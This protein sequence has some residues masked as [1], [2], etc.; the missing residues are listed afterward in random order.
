[1]KNDVEIVA[2]VLQG[3]TDVFESI[4]SRYKGCVYGLALTFLKDFDAA[5]DVAQEVF[6]RAF[7]NLDRLKDGDKLSAWLRSITA[8]TCKKWL[9]QRRDTLSITSQD[10]EGFVPP[11]LLPETPDRV[12]ERE[13]SRRIVLDGLSVLSENNRQALTLYYIDGLST[14]EIASFLGVSTAA[15]RQR[16]RR[17]LKQ[18]KK[19]MVNM[20]KDTLEN[21]TPKDEFTA[22]LNQLLAEVKVFFLRTDFQAAIPL[23]QQA[24]EIAPDDTLVALLLSDAYRSTDTAEEPIE[25]YRKARTILQNVIKKEPDN[26]FARFYL[27]R[28]EAGWE[29]SVYLVQTHEAFIARAKGGPFEALG[30]FSLGC[31]HAPRGR[32]KE[33]V[34]HFQKAMVLDPK[35]AGTVY[36][37]MAASYQRNGDDKGSIKA[38]NK[39]IGALEHTTSEDVA[40]HLKGLEGESYWHF[41]DHPDSRLIKLFQAHSRLAGLHKKE[42]TDTLAREH[43]RTAF[44][45][46]N[47]EEMASA[48]DG[49]IREF[50]AKVE[51]TFP[52]LTDEK[53]VQYLLQ[54][55]QESD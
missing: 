16:I 22:R 50:M 6:L 52:E 46:L 29:K 30:H 8:N 42:G 39:A 14:P 28:L 35:C 45:Y 26:L 24:A 23:L 41:F 19:E 27:M 55:A 32:H 15:I 7:L 34:T 49:V 12:W 17:S 51:N 10:W 54:E 9:R 37:E 3:E 33:A 21:E 20:V 31:V 47:K 13:E 18:L 2:R 25:K 38:L 1:M 5:H 40:D 43:L 11:D 4:V 44:D 36:I 53:I 48:R